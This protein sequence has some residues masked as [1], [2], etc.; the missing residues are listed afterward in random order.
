MAC[1]MDLREAK[2]DEGWNALHAAAA[3]GHLEVCRFLLEESGLDVNCTEADGERRP[4][5]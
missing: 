3:K 5:C 1:Q 2:D 4:P